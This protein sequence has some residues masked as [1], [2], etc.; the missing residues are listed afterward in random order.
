M[1][2]FRIILSSVRLF[3]LCFRH[4][5]FRDGSLAWT[6]CFPA[7]IFKPKVR[8]YTLT[9]VVVGLANSW[10]SEGASVWW[11]ETTSFSTKGYF[12]EFSLFNGV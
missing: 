6:A 5:L 10:R 12:V 7:K 9:G 2:A 8:V 1:N 11:S 4:C 3:D